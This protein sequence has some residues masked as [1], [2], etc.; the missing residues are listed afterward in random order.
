LLLNLANLKELLIRT[1]SPDGTMLVQDN[2]L[3]EIIGSLLRPY[4]GIG[5]MLL[6]SIWSNSRILKGRAH[7]L[8]LATFGFSIMTALSNL[9]TSRTALLTSFVIYA[10]IYSS[11]V[12][13]VAIWKLVV[14]T[15]FLLF[16]NIE[17]G[18]LRETVTTGRWRDEVNDSSLTSKFSTTLQIYAGGPQLL[19]F[20]LQEFD[21][22]NHYYLGKTIVYSILS[23]IPI[24]GT[25]FRDNNGATIFNDMIYGNHAGVQDQVIPFSL[26]LWM[27]GGIFGIFI[28]YFALGCGLAFAQ[29]YYVS[30]SSLTTGV[31]TTYASFMLG[32]WLALLFMGSLSVVSQYIIYSGLP[33]LS[34]IYVLR[35]I[36][37]PLSGDL[38]IQSRNGKPTEFIM[39]PASKTDAIE[40]GIFRP[41][42]SA[43]GRQPF[44]RRF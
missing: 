23:P 18:R 6:W 28:G 10:A 27:N 40:R 4:F 29:A 43:R 2:Q 41:R 24:A 16:C 34:C 7:L 37:K 30:S 32:Y 1:S 21:N 17:L 39:S 8:G 14:I 22:A 19:A 38:F 5:L 42:S 11:R 26:E 9:G 20:G 13:P 36:H 25:F 31:F 33:I 12:K 3:Y 15:S 44:S 35:I